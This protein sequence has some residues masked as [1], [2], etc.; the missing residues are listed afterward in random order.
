MKVFRDLKK[1]GKT[2]IVIS[3]QERILK[4]VDKILVLDKGKVKE[5]KEAR[6]ILPKI[7]EVKDGN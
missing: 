2:I 7:L 5:F 3:H 1:A 4:I 6:K